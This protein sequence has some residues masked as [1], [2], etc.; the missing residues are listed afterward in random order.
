MLQCG[1][2]HIVLQMSRPQLCP[3]SG[4]YWLRKGVPADLLAVVGGRARG[5]SAWIRRLGPTDRAAGTEPLLRHRLKTLGR[6]HGLTPDLVTAITG[7]G[8][9]T[10]ADSYGEFEMAVLHRE[11]IKIPPLV[12]SIRMRMSP[13]AQRVG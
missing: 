4:V 9:R 7:Q 5:T 8:K 1:A 10:V 11:L 2:T 12:L 13:S 6:R 3:R